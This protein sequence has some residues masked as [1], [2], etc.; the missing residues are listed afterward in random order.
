MANEIT[1]TA[2]LRVNKGNL[3]YQSR[4]QVFTADLNT[5]EGP[6]VGALEISTSG[7]II[8]LSEMSQ[9]G[10]GRITNLDDTNRVEFGIW[11]GTSVFYPWGEWLPGE[12]WPFRL[13]RYLQGPGTAGTWD[14][15]GLAY[16]A[17]VVALIEIFE[18]V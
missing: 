2:G 18:G 15:R 11:D 9:P 16:G 5:A 14:L 6:F 12:T 17:N 4:P 3:D 7:T 1:V 8:D 10:V 13:S